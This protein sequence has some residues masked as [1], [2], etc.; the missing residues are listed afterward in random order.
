MVK[1]RLDKRGR[2]RLSRPR[3]EFNRGDNPERIGLFDIAEGMRV[4]LPAGFQPNARG[5]LTPMR[6]AY[7]E[8]HEAVDKMFVVLHGGAGRRE[9]YEGVKI[10]GK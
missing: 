2:D 3:G 8:V 5:V 1:R 4:S 6:P 10:T 9:M 7:L